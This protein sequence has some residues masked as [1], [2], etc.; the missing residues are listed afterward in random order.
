LK[1]LIV[2]VVADLLLSLHVI[3]VVV[4]ADI[5]SELGMAGFGLGVCHGEILET[6]RQ[7]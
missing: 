3:R 7:G 5:V 1:K 6:G 4:L 2:S